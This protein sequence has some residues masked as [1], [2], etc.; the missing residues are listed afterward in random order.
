MII[1]QGN[2]YP[3]RLHLLPVLLSNL[4]ANTALSQ[5]ATQHHLMAAVAP[6][7]CSDQVDA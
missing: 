5:I 7:M 3:V 6:K 1:L 4:S 2:L